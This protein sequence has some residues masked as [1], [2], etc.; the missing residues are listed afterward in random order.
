MLTFVTTSAGLSSSRTSI[1][2]MQELIV[3]EEREVFIDEI[4]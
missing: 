2:S 4:L 3:C 1:Y